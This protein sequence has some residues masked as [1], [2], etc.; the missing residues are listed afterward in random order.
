MSYT[1]FEIRKVAEFPDPGADNYI[2]TID[3]QQQQDFAD[4]DAIGQFW[5]VYGRLP[6]NE[7][8]LAEAVAISDHE[9]H[10]EAV[11]AGQ[12]LAGDRPLHDRS[13]KH[14]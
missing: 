14:D 8:G 1:E 4:D 12:R 9:T 7:V 13:F 10:A 2:E 5:T 11:L 3:D 6:P